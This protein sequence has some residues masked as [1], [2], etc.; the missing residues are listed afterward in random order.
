[1]GSAPRWE[2]TGERDDEA[3]APRTYRPR[4][5]FDAAP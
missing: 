1:L 3:V 2:K 4:I 5:V